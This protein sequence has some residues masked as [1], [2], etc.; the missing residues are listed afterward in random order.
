MIQTVNKFQ[1]EFQMNLIPNVVYKVKRNHE[2]HPSRFGR[3]Q[4]LGGPEKKS[5]V[6]QDLSDK[7]VSFVVGLNDLMDFDPEKDQ[8]IETEQL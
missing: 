5:I 3:F 1:T 6:L 7:R 4:F 8:I 2:H